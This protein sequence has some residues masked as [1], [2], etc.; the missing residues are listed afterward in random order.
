MSTSKT[1]TYYAVAKGHNP[2]IYNNWATTNENVKGFSGAIYEGFKT[3]AEAQQYLDNYNLK[4]PPIEPPISLL[5]TLTEQQLAVIDHLLE[6]DN[7]FLTGGGGVGKSYLLSVI[8]T[9]F[10]GLKKRII[11][12]KDPG[13]IAKLPRIQMCAMTGCAALLLGHKAKTLH[14]W[15]GI[16]LGKGSVSELYVKIRRNQ[17]SM[18]NWLCT[19]LLIIDEVSMMTAE[20][21]DKLN[22]IGKKVRGNKKPFGGIQ[23]LLVG[24]FFQL[25]PVNRSDETTK[26]AF[27]SDA[28]KELI[29][30][31]IELTEIQRQKDEI[32]QRVLKEARRGALTK[33]SCELLTG[34]QGRDWK[35]N[36]IRPT[37]LFP[38]RA[39]VD[40]INDSNL[41]SLTGRRYTYKARLVYDGKIPEG[42]SESNEGFQ[43]A[44]QMFDSDA[45]YSKELE[46]MLNAQVMLIA[47]TDPDS[48]LVNGSR[49][50]VV[51]FCPSTELPIV[52]FLNGV[53]K[54]VGTHTW[55]IE[56][57]EF[58]SRAQVPLKLAYAVTIHKS[59]G[60]TLDSALVDIGSGVFEYG[61]AYVALSRVR[62]LEALY[63]YDFD[64]T[65]FK[66]H[67][68]VKEFYK[69]LK[70][71]EINQEDMALIK[72]TKFEHKIENLENPDMKPIVAE[73]SKPI[74]AIN[75]I[76]Q[77]DSTVSITASGSLDNWL[78]DTAPS[79]WKDCLLPCRDKLLEIS[80]TLSTKEF[81]PSRENIWRALELTPL[82][83]IKVVILGQDPYPTPGNAHGLAF[84]VMPDVRPVPASLK[85]IYKELV[86][87]IG[88]VS[89]NHGNLEEWAKRGVML[90]NTVLTVEAGS[91]QSHTK[92][93]W[94]EVT[95]QIIRSIAA[96]SK[97]V[98]FVLWGKSAQVKKKLLGLYLDKNG[99]RVFESAHPSPLS[100][101]KGFLGSKPFSKVNG[102]LEE[103]GKEKIDWQFY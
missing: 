76:K 90:L 92:I 62:S 15:A 99:H 53:K 67:P 2:G 80:N 6:G 48:G 51:G 96:Q 89:P 75:V 63:V 36:K 56:D 33:D 8:Y 5:D 47:N 102:W 3:M 98:I 9:E 91:P 27:E 82:S 46:L 88:F 54:P 100:A 4:N 23:V 1:T 28:W 77:D 43:K 65:A 79:G 26:F 81:L 93:G 13:S 74:H 7:L 45:A 50:I 85:N 86:S 32:F 73:S 31:S 60:A 69:N 101:S 83:S 42:F 38:R 71:K 94:E 35:E 58:V 49:G 11:A 39:E 78:Y 14:S 55:P 20:L 52:E 16:G 70:I 68:K 72:E 25:P 29:T 97:N 95:D 37:L 44:L 87:D 21:L 22:E 41:R 24:D 64:P 57:Y 19:D 17:K 10:P 12:A 103:M 40:M 61:Q 66:A 18:K 34:Y 84:S 30:S 59:Q